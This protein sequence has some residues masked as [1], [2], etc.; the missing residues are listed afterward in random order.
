MI[1]RAGRGPDGRDPGPLD[2]AADMVSR[3]FSDMIVE[4]FRLFHEADLSKKGK[5]MIK[6]LPKGIS[7]SRSF[8]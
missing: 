4:I 3:H 8:S 7:S 5:R 2:G 1:G 6:I